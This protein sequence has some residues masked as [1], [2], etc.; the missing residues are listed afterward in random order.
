[1]APSVRRFARFV[2]ASIVFVIAMTGAAQTYAAEPADLSVSAAWVGNGNPRAA[3]GETVAYKITVTN[4]GPGTATGVYLVP[5]TPDQFN[6]VS[7]ECANAVFCSSP[8]G[9]L[10]PGA[11][12]TAT[13]VDVVCCF[14]KGESR[15][16]SAGAAVISDAD[17]DLANDNSSV[18]TRIVGPYGFFFPG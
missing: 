10:A 8:G 2:P 11:T 14:P 7:L 4:L 15:T 5:L 17:P 9:A 16:T 6:P 3:V 1:M 13:V 18:V 12:V